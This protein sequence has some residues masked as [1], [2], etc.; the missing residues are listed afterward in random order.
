MRYL[1]LTAT[2]EDSHETL[3]R[4]LQAVHG[5]NASRAP[6]ARVAVAFPGM[7]EALIDERGKVLQVPKPGSQLRVFGEEAALLAFATSSTPARMVKL[8]MVV[9][10]AV[11]DVPA[12][13]G[14]VRF[15]RDRSFER[16][17]ANGAYA[18]RQARRAE[19]RGETAGRRGMA[20]PRTFGFH[21]RSKSTQHGFHVDVRKEPAHQGFN[22]ANIS[23]YGLCSEGSAVPW[24]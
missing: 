13:A 4:L 10:S 12:G 15:V 9:R 24:F 21:L 3:A 16:H 7:Q 8:G 11:C 17:H 23:S 5:F 20:E 1:N 18:R 22:L 14:A 19:A 6:N 2:G